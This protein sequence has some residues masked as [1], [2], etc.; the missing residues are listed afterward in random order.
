MAGGR[1]DICSAGEVQSPASDVELEHSE[2]SVHWPG[3]SHYQK[4]RCKQDND[5]CV[6]AVPVMLYSAGLAVLVSRSMTC[7]IMYNHGWV[8]FGNLSLKTNMWCVC[9]IKK[10]IVILFLKI[11][12][13]Y[14]LL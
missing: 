5:H 1:A 12:N 14:L 4:I 6:R 8:S 10:V 7:T 3:T 2:Q 13:K 9:Q 11:I